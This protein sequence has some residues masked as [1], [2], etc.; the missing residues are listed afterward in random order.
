MKF[1]VGD[2]VKIK[3]QIHDALKTHV[4][5]EE[6]VGVIRN[7]DFI[8]KEKYNRSTTI[9]LICGTHHKTYFVCQSKSIPFITLTECEITHSLLVKTNKLLEL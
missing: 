1:K 3:K 4:S 9:C 6:Y 7:E 2:R 5:D 8:I